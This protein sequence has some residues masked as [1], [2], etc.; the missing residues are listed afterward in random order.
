MMRFIYQR[1]H[2]VNTS[3]RLAGQVFV[4]KNQQVLECT[5]LVVAGYQQP[6]FRL[7]SISFRLGPQPLTVSV[8]C[9]RSR[10]ILRSLC[11]GAV[12]FHSL[13]L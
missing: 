7:S 8:S 9:G 12:A 13:C 10:C 2:E 11:A 4:Q 3:S 1:L 6:D 5:D